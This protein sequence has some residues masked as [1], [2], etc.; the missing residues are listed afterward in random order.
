M[1]HT[2]PR[3]VAGEGFPEP[4]T[5]GGTQVTNRVVSK[6]DAMSSAFVPTSSAET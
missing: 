5:A 3:A 1:A 6:T 4:P 2:T